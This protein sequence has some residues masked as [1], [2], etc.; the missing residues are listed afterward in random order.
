MPYITIPVKPKYYQYNFEDILYGVSERKFR[1]METNRDTK[2][3]KTTWRKK[4][5]DQLTEAYPVYRTFVKPLQEF[6]KKYSDLFSSDTKHLYRHFTIPKRSGKPRPIDAPIDSFMEVLR[7]LKD[8]FEKNLF[9]SYHTAAFAY[10]RGRCSKTAVM[11]HQANKSKWRLS[12]DFHNFFGSTTMDFLLKQLGYIYPFSEILQVP[13][14]RDYL[15]KPLSLCFLNGGLPQGTPTSPMLTNIMMI[16]IDHAI[17]RYA[18]EHKPHLVYTRYADDIALSSDRR[19]D[20]KSV[21][22]DIKDILSKAE[23]PFSLNDE[24]TRYGS[25]AGRNWMLGLM[26]NKDNEITVGHKKKKMFSHMLLGFL[27]SYKDGSP[28]SVEDTRELAGIYSYYKSVQ[29]KVFSD[30]VE[31]YSTKFGVDFNLAV[32]KIL[33]GEV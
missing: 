22:N 31:K 3:T 25:S 1:V 4:V 14:W 26:L 23:A 19:F 8:I 17:S 33:R 20:E 24:K 30:M 21:T 12:L 6:C 27:T 28:W 13:Q 5:P 16:P 18:R 9:A 7:E 2:D 10:V 32:K 29:D 11:R 15:I